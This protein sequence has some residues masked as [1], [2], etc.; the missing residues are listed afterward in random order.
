MGYVCVDWSGRGLLSGKERTA[1]QRPPTLLLQ[2]ANQ[3]DKRVVV[4][5]QDS[6]AYKLPDSSHWLSSFNSGATELSGTFL[7]YCLVSH[8]D[9][10]I[11]NG[12]G[13]YE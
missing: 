6:T 13:A 10:I 4:P 3:S 2:N 11:V 7:L 12:A 5:G 8:P 9:N 1:K